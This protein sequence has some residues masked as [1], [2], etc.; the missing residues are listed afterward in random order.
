VE[1]TATAYM[2]GLQT[3]LNT[4]TKHRGLLS[5]EPPLMLK[6]FI[7]EETHM[8][9]MWK[10]LREETPASHQNSRN[11][12]TKTSNNEVRLDPK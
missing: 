4:S 10:F 3:I 9:C 12:D 6:R 7:R 5:K 2:D 11:Q 1:L 8:H